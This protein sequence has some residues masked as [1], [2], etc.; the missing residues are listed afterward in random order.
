MKEGETRES[1]EAR[2]QEI[3]RQVVRRR[4][5]AA[6]AA[7]FNITPRAVNDVVEK[8]RRER[9][10]LSKRDPVEIVEDMLAE[11]QAAMDDLGEVA[12]STTYD[13]VKVG[14]IRQRM[15]CMRDM[16]ELM[17]ETGTLP[18]DLGQLKLSLELNVIAERFMLVLSQHDA[19]EPLV[20]AMME[21]LRPGLPAG[22]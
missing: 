16:R 22:N 10:Q 19:P 7:E 13:A 14:A 12:L 6:I 15:A 3:I 5:K 17:Q 11:Y 20:A 9:P 21:A 2:N 18:K 4:P 1:L 8:W